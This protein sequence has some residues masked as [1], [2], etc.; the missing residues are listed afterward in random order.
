[1]GRQDIAMT[2][3]NAYSGSVSSLPAADFA[4]LAAA[5]D[6]R[7]C[8]DEHG[9]GTY[10]EAAAIYRPHPPCPRCGFPGTGRDG[11]TAS[12]IQRFEC[13]VCGCRYNALTG[14]VLEFSKK[15]MPTWA[16]FIDL[17][18]FGAPLDCISVACGITHQTAF[19]WRHRVFEA[20]DGYQGRI[21]L[22]GRVW[23]DETYVSDTDLSHGYGEARRRGLSKQLVCI[24]VAI[25]EHKNAVAVACG[26]GK[27]S[28]AR[29]KA[30]LLAHLEP[31]S[32]VIH[33]KE[34]SHRGLIKAAKCSDL[35]YKADVS[36][37]AYIEA[38][39]MVNN[40]CSWLKR[41]LW[42]FTGMSP[43]NL[44]SYLN[45][46][47]Y[48]FRVNQAR[49]RWPETERVVRHLLMTEARFRSST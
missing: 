3:R 17:M 30:A 5:V 4:D 35:A 20:V 41:Y 25:D 29:M 14:T 49:E 18:R 32:L 22:R 26:H 24:A 33:D 46:Y 37:P 39:A 16:R 10:A 31:G 9:F 43:R 28:T 36:D 44:Q 2:T 21:V 11:R 42:R 40:L 1:M 13:S 48:L 7:R 19:E 8:R 38:M 6:E 12:G 15:D 45:W 23:I 47:A 34:R 27:P